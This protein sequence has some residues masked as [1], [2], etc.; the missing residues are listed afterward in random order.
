MRSPG[1]MKEGVL[2]GRAPVPAPPA[3]PLSSGH[4]RICWGRWPR[5]GRS[6]QNETTLP[7]CA[8]ALDLQVERESS[9]HLSGP[10]ITSDGEGGIELIHRFGNALSMLWQVSLQGDGHVWQPPYVPARALSVGQSR[11][12]RQPYGPRLPKSG[13]RAAKRERRSGVQ[14]HCRAGPVRAVPER[15][16]TTGN[17]CGGPGEDMAG[18]RAG[19]VGSGEPTANAELGLSGRG[20][21]AASERGGRPLP[22]AL[23]APSRLAPAWQLR[24]P[25]GLGGAR[26]AAPNTGWARRALWSARGSGS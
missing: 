9:P 19:P 6:Y 13:S 17:S 3:A 2:G 11:P 25:A 5:V 24:H 10:P 7:P 16:E 20:S 4:G 23:P 8:C 15:R 18:A 22:R 26:G 14:G 21:R 1:V 12:G